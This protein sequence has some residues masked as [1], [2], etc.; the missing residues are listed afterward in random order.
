M[1][2]GHAGVPSVTARHVS[3]RKALALYDRFEPKPFERFFSYD[4]KVRLD[5]IKQFLLFANIP[6]ADADVLFSALRNGMIERAERGVAKLTRDAFMQKIYDDLDGQAD[7]LDFH[8]I[9]ENPTEYVDAEIT[10]RAAR[11][12]S[13]RR[14]G[15]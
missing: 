14:P 11:P 9:A 2:D 6:A 15:S 12:P 3:I 8:M 13:S 7:D 4:A 10:S 1:T 5:A